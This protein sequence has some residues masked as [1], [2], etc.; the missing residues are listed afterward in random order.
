MNKAQRSIISKGALE[1]EMRWGWKG[2]LGH[3]A[4][5]LLPG[6]TGPKYAH[7]HTQPRVCLHVCTQAFVSGTGLH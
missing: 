5:V 2:D 3:Q 7:A 4:L 6:A 1:N